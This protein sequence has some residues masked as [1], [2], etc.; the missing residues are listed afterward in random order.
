MTQ[1]RWMLPEGVEEILPP[2]AW[3]VEL[4]RR[5]LLDLYRSWGYELIMPPLVEYLDSLLTGAGEALEQQT[6]KLTDQLSGRTLGLRADVTPQ[7]ARIDANRMAQDVP[8]RLCYIDSVLRTRP[9]SDGDARTL[10]QVGCELFGHDGVDSDREVIALMLET[11]AAAGVPDVH[12]D[13]GHVGVFRALAAHAGLQPDA[14]AEIFDLLQ[15]KSR[16]DLAAA[17]IGDVAKPLF[18]ALMGMNG[19]REVIDRARDAFA[20]CG[21]A[22][23]QALDAMDTTLE[24]L[25]TA[26][27]TLPVHVDLAELRGYRYHTG[28]VFGAFIA[29]HGREL[30]R[31]GR[32]N[33]VG[34]A[35]GS[36]RAATGFSANLH[37]LL[38]FGQQ[39]DAPMNA[40][41]AQPEHSDEHVRAARASG[42]VV[43]RGLPGAADPAHTATFEETG[44]SW[45]VKPA[46]SKS[47]N[48]T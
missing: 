41:L 16:P 30:A 23:E 28:L 40:A 9:A 33:N 42:Q 38:R 36:G 39:A 46:P 29:D 6:F 20:G 15:R 12:I 47:G 31:G 18:E 10:R 3:Q 48:S 44:E 4:L 22:V 2:D 25:A 37:D 7:A 13:V 8:A 11:L 21:S 34:A 24:W 45:A 19:G 17:A 43:V 1:T 35:F 32:Y 27:P 14:E 5:K 26:H